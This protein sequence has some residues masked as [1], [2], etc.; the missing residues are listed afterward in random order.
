MTKQYVINPKTNRSLLVG[1]NL[2][3]KLVE[4]GVLEDDHTVKHPKELYKIKDG[5]TDE[6]IN[7]LKQE[8]KTDKYFAVKGRGHR[9]KNKL[10]KRTKGKSNPKPPPKEKTQYKVKSESEESES[11]SEESEESESDNNWE[12]DIEN[13]LSKSDFGKQQKKE[14]QSSLEEE[15]EDEDDE[16]EDEDEDEDDDEDE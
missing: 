5:D 6:K 11:E 8:L 2:W 15:E 13:M 1:G 7:Q 12:N 14:E 4:E 10:V 9:L 16:D 3:L